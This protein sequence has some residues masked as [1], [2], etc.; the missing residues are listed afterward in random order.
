MEGVTLDALR[1]NGWMRLNYADPFVPFADGFP[2]ASGKLEL[3]SRRAQRDGLDPLPGYVPPAESA[4][5]ADGSLVL[6]SAASHWFLN[7]TFA[8]GETHRRR[9]GE[10]TVV[11]HPSDAAARGLTDGAAVRIGNERGSFPALLAIS[12]DARPGVAATTKG[13]WPKLLGAGNANST[14]EERDAD[15]GRGAVFHDNA[16]TVEAIDPHQSERKMPVN[17]A[18][19][20]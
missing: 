17:G 11:L 20:G 3:W 16:V 18:T 4:S 13:W 9:A 10:P 2:T 12:D 19:A 7:S 8:N 1:A 6:I 15:M 14:V 5:A